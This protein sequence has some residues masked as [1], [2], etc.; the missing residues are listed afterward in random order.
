MVL[1]VRD[2]VLVE[3][4]Q[5]REKVLANERSLQ[6]LDKVK[7][8]VC[9]GEDRVVLTDQVANYYEI[10][11]PTLESV[12]E[13]HKEELEE[14]GLKTIRKDD[15]REFKGNIQ[16]EDIY[17]KI[18][19][20]R[21]LSLFTPK[22]VLKIGM[23]LNDSLVA[24]EVKEQVIKSKE[25]NLINELALVNKRKV[26]E[27]RLKYQL[28]QA[29]NGICSFETQ[30]KCGSYFIDFV[31]NGNIAVECDENGHEDRKPDYELK[32]EKLIKN[33]G[34][35]LIRYNPDSEDTVFD[36]IN[37]VMRELI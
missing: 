13:D 26:K 8:L 35:K 27:N 18:K 23:L 32:R 34:Y 25:E 30:V 21:H 20:S 22:T 16:K 2:D 24:A 1:I 11:K 14:D 12:I 17:S 36:L 5:A 33:E 3:N 28:L 31:L 10:P 19:Y 4:K 15:L 7:E 29:F 6:V 37:R 9:L